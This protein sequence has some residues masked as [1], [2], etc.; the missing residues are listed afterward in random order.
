MRSPLSLQMMMYDLHP[1]VAK[2]FVKNPSVSDR[3]VSVC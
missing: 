2:I 1:E 3:E